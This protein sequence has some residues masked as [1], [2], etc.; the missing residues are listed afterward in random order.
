MQLQRTPFLDTGTVTLRIET[1]NSGTPS[2]T[3]V[4]NGS[5]TLDVSAIPGA[6]WEGSGWVQFTF[7]TPPSLT[8]A[9]DYWIVLSCDGV[10]SGNK[11]LSWNRF[12]SSGDTAKYSTNSGATYGSTDSNV[13]LNFK[14]VSSGAG[15]SY[16]LKVE[17]TKRFL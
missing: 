13:A 14:L 7:A 5:A 4:T 8:A 16:D 15:W 1:D 3:L 2:G 17:Y 12:N 9:T 10:G 11:T 6:N